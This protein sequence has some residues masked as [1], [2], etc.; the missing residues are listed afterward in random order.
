MQPGEAGE[1]RLEVGRL[2]Q[3]EQ[4]VREQRA[5]EL[6][7]SLV[8]GSVSPI[9][10]PAPVAMELMLL[11]WA[12]S[13][14]LGASSSW[15]VIFAPALVELGVDAVEHPGGRAGQRDDQDVRAVER[16]GDE[17]R[18]EG[19]RELLGVVDPALQR[20]DLVGEFGAV[21]P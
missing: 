14:K 4:D 18:A 13:V 16:A 2:A 9:G 19:R 6:P 5:A 20:L 15:P 3:P 8:S 17:L 21:G 11:P 10:C 12:G 7:G 1:H